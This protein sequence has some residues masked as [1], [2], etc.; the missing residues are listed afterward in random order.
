MLSSLRLLGTCQS[1]EKIV[2]KA[3]EIWRLERFS[4]SHSQRSRIRPRMRTE[5]TCVKVIT[6]PGAKVEPTGGVK[7]ARRQK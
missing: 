5:R 6:T 2:R 1:E 4:V 7:R 3:L